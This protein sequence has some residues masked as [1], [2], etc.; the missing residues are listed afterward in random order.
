MEPW[1]ARLNLS[2]NLGFD[3]TVFDRRG[4]FEYRCICISRIIQLFTQCSNPDYS[5]FTLRNLTMVWNHVGKHALKY[6]FGSCAASGIAGA[7][8][9]VTTKNREDLQHVHVFTNPK[10]STP[11]D[12]INRKREN[13]ITWEEYFMA[14]AFLSA[15]RSKDPNT[16]VGACIVNDENKIVGIGYNGMPLGCPDDEMPWARRADSILDT[17]KLFV[18]H[19]EMNAILNKNSSSVQG[20][21]IYVA[22]FP[23]NECAKLIIQSGIKE[24][25]YFSDK[26]K[27]H[28]EFVASRQMLEKARVNVRPFVRSRNQIVIDFSSIDS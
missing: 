12:F 2:E 20:C 18:C 17:K 16:Q 3:S 14:V 4:L 28:I 1:Q 11:K 8:G 6:L 19:A 27:E 23:C 7:A 13:F 26:Y 15:Q 25:I 10:P 21:R 5:T 22:L 24:V 9:F